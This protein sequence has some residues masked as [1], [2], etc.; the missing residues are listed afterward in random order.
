LKQF[1]DTLEQR[2]PELEKQLQT[3]YQ[4][5]NKKELELQTQLI[6]DMEALQYQI[7]S[8]LTELERHLSLLPA[9]LLQRPNVESIKSHQET[10]V[11]KAT[12][13]FNN[14]EHNQSLCSATPT[15]KITVEPEEPK[16][17]TL[18]DFGISQATLAVISSEAFAKKTEQ[19]QNVALS[20]THKT[21]SSDIFESR[22]LG[23]AISM[24][25]KNRERVQSTR[26]EIEIVN[27]AATE[28]KKL[29]NVE[30][31]ELQHLRTVLHGKVN[32]AEL[33]DIIN[34]LNEN[35]FATSN[36]NTNCENITI[37]KTELQKVLNAAGDKI[38]IILLALIDLKRLK[39]LSI[40]GNTVYC[41]MRRNF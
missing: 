23:G 16:T 37:S 20:P 12:T 18:E 10:S 14:S 25:P 5:V 41:I 21:S 38:Q 34:K 8:A 27:N 2:V 28:T 19:L 40:N 17:P 30:E 32:I 33:N 35:Y 39:P 26:E 31:N 29:K 24:V 13:V 9:Q 11:S 3:A 6:V 22:E 36:P 1:F 15:N 7:E 4:L